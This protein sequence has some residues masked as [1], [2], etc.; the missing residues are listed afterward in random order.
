VTASLDDAGSAEQR[1]GSI[2]DLTVLGIFGRSTSS[3]VVDLRSP[4]PEVARSDPVVGLSLD[5]VSGER[6][7]TKAIGVQIAEAIER[8]GASTVIVGLGA[9]GGDE[10]EACDAALLSRRRARK[11]IRWIVYSDGD[12]VDTGRIA[13][14][15]M[16]L[17]VRGIRLEPVLLFDAADAADDPARYWEVRS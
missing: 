7:A 13:R 8:T 10:L 16:F 5:R 12:P 6:T 9:R 15:C 1:F 3:D 2:P 4:R 11:G 14:R 17:L